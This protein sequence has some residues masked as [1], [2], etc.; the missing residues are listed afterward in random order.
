MPLRPFRIL[1]LD[2]G[3]IHG[4]IA[5]EILAYLETTLQM[6][7]HRMFD[8]I[9]GVSTGG[10]IA[11]G[12]TMPLTPEPVT[13]SA[14]AI[15]DLYLRLCPLIFKPRAP[16]PWM[17]YL[18]MGRWLNPL[19]SSRYD[20]QA[21]YS[22]YTSIFQKSLLSQAV[23]PVLIPVYD[24]AH[25]QTQAPQVR[26][27]SSLTKDRVRHSPM[28]IVH[29]TW[30]ADV[31]ASTCAAPTYFAPQSIHHVDGKGRVLPSMHRFVDGGVAINNPALAAVIHARTL[32]PARPISILSLGLSSENWPNYRALQG[33]K[34]PG[35]LD[36]GSHL[37][38]LMIH[39]PMSCHEVLLKV[40]ANQAHTHIRYRRM[41]PQASTGLDAFDD[42][43]PAHI[44][45]IQD[46]AQKMIHQN[47]Q[48]LDRFADS[49]LTG[50]SF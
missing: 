29:D 4:L 12:L 2:G 19:F 45:R 48:E 17:Q 33:R 14:R 23:C 44:A 16:L 18:P 15:A 37:S 6:P 1:S 25:T 46:H 22:V 31:A 30:M 39:P 3:G 7:C 36:W 20:S 13:H 27:F 32:Y 49:V 24:I 50:Q 9:A 26:F 40:M 42:I 47:K 43:S 38:E 41:V 28:Y 10:L 21:A 11:L 35:Y 5:L 8:L 34:N